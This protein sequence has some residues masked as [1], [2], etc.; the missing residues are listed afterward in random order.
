MKNYSLQDFKKDNR[1]NENLGR[2]DWESTDPDKYPIHKFTFNETKLHKNFQLLEQY[3]EKRSAQIGMVPR[4]GDVIHLENNQMV[5]ISRVSDEIIQTAPNGSFNTMTG[6]SFSF[7]GGHN[8]LTKIS[9]LEPTYEKDFM[10]MWFPEGGHLR[11]GSK[12]HG[13]MLVNV[14]KLRPGADTSEIWNTTEIK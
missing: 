14:W 2:W 1:G 13:K 3:Q 7:S 12:I 10:E 6:A 11:A 8:G 5:L 9:D 4:V